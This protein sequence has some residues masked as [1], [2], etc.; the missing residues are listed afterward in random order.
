MRARLRSPVCEVCPRQHFP[1]RHLHED[2]IFF[3]F[4]DWRMTEEEDVDRAEDTPFPDWTMLSA[5]CL[6]AIKF[7]IISF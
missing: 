1:C 3:F 6:V 2:S 5:D 4:L 7:L